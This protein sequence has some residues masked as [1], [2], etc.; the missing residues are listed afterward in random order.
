MPS[1]VVDL[2]FEDS[3]YFLNYL[4]FTGWE[5]YDGIAAINF[6][7]QMGWITSYAIPLHL[8]VARVSE[9]ATL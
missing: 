6:A 5:L 4:K 9:R 1:F 2:F 8:V 3:S 7:Y